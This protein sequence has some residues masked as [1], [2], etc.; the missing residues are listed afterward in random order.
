MEGCLCAGVWEISACSHHSSTIRGTTKSTS[1]HRDPLVSRPS[2]GNS[3]YSSST[4]IAINDTLP[5]IG[6]M[7]IA[8]EI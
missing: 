2:C 7:S 3:E 6:T 4:F 8:I 1:W 5:A